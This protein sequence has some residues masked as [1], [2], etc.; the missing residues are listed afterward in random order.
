MNIEPD[1]IVVVDSCVPQEKL[2]RGVMEFVVVVTSSSS[3]KSQ[4]GNPPTA[5]KAVE[6]QPKSSAQPP[7]RMLKR[8]KSVP[9]EAAAEEIARVT[10]K[11]FD[12]GNL[13]SKN[14]NNTSTVHF[15]VKAM[16][17]HIDGLKKKFSGEEDAFVDSLS[18]YESNYFRF[19][20]GRLLQCDDVEQCRVIA[21]LMKDI[22]PSLLSPLGKVLVNW[23][24]S[25]GAL[26]ADYSELATELQLSQRADLYQSPLFVSITK[27]QQ[28]RK[29]NEAKKAVADGKRD[30]EVQAILGQLRDIVTDEEIEKELS[31]AQG[32]LPVRMCEG[33]LLVRGT[34]ALRLVAQVGAGEERA[35]QLGGFRE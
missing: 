29:L 25:D 17:K 20:C 28:I 4:K 24:A 10:K 6:A 12:A 32:F 22:S 8:C 23:L 14:P 31:F 15:W 13:T 34:G 26:D 30:E 9:D 11:A 19:V 2:G 33:A 1:D 5:V 27:L 7:E 3:L 18:E 35:F 16:V 21:L